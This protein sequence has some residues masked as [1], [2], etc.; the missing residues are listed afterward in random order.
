VRHGDQV[1]SPQL[2]MLSDGV[3]GLEQAYEKLLAESGDD[4]MLPGAI[5]YDMLMLAGYVCGGWQ[6]LRSAALVSSV[7]NSTFVANKKATVAYYLEHML[8]RFKANLESLLAGSASVMAIS[9][10]ML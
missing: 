5:S 4:P 8:P 3:D 2:A 7:D 1:S 6:M 9:A 10:D